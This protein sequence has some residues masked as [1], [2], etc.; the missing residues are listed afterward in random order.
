M[1]LLTHLEHKKASQKP[2]DALL[3]YNCSLKKFDPIGFIVPYCF[4]TGSDVKCFG[5]L[6]IGRLISPNS[7]V[8]LLYRV[9][10]CRESQRTQTICRERAFQAHKNNSLPRFS[11]PA[12]TNTFVH[13]RQQPS[14]LFMGRKVAINK[15][16]GQSFFLSQFPY[17]NSL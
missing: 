6:L 16:I 2:S 5:R 4:P 9:P 15:N 17:R 12:N 14:P 10:P 11:L 1:L 13:L 8:C 7:F 3:A